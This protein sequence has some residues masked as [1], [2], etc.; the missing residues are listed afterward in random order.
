LSQ[1]DKNYRKVTKI[2]TEDNLNK[3][4]KKVASE[5][6]NDARGMFGNKGQEICATE[7]ETVINLF[8]RFLLLKFKKL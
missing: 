4:Y 3:I 2:V 6:H 7:T 1:G 5:I 8:I